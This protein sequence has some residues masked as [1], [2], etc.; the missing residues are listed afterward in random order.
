MRR[1]SV[2]L[3][4]LALLALAASGAPLWACSVP[5][6]RYALERWPADPYAAVVFHRGPLSADQGRWLQRLRAAA[7]NE[8][9]PAN[10][11]VTTVDLAQ[12]EE[13][14]ELYNQAAAKSLPWLVLTYPQAG[15][16]GGGPASPVADGRI[17]A[18]MPFDA[19][20]VD[21]L[22]DSPV[23]QRIARGLLAGDSAVWVFVE[24][25]DKAADL[26][27]KKALQDNL[28]KLAKT[29]ELPEA[30]AEYADDAPVDPVATALADE[31]TEK[32]VPFRLSFSVVSLS[33]QDAAER[34]L[35]DMLM[36]SESDL[37]EL[38]NQP[39][40][41]PVFGRGRAL[42]ALVGRGLTTDNITEACDF[43]TGPCSCQVKAL[44]PGTD[45]L[46][47]VNWEGALA[48]LLPIDDAIPPLVGI[49]PTIE[50][51]AVAPPAAVA[52]AASAAGESDSL[53]TN[54]LLALALVIVAATVGT[55]LVKRRGAS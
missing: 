25:G 40:A 34:L 6:F 30:M 38:A 12:A 55:L 39:M 8:A 29:L 24:S 37:A 47:A 4:A 48:D 23:R 2:S 31:E 15:S 19:K 9:H 3:P 26:A 45:L 21:H 50:P 52:P 41:F 27:A 16:E 43:L 5:V 14:P 18:S 35:L 10:L 28:D 33:R 42:Y 32:G 54:L 36:H 11:Q 17:A 51:P 13:A 1:R 22:T 53:V 46:M 49:S 7:A 20:A 44:N